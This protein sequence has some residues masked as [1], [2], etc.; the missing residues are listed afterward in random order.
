MEVEKGRL[1]SRGQFGNSCDSHHMRGFGA[2]N[3]EDMSKCG[4][5]STPKIRRAEFEGIWRLYLLVT[6][7]S[8]DQ[9]E[10]HK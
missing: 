8:Y 7:S 5:K 6:L 9:F 10:A 1:I 2:E 4:M 3:Q